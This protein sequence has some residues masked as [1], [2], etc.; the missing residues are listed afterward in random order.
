LDTYKTSSTLPIV[1]QRLMS[2]AFDLEKEDRSPKA[3]ELIAA[4]VERPEITAR[5]RVVT[6]ESRAEG[7]R[8]R[9]SAVTKRGEATSREFARFE[10]ANEA[11]VAPSEECAPPRGSI[12]LGHLR[13]RRR[14]Q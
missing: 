3:A 11:K 4:V 2:L 12:K 1:V 14:F 13:P 10:A 5:L 9:L 8:S 7:M 6:S